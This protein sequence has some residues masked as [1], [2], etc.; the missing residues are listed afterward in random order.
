MSLKTKILVVDDDQV[1]CELL[2]EFL[3]SQGF[4]VFLA[5]CTEQ[6]LEKATQNKISLV[7][8]DIRMGDSDGLTLLQKL[9]A[10]DPFLVMIMMT[11]FGSV[12]GTIEAIQKGAFDYISKPFDLARLLALIQ[13]A[14]KHLDSLKG[15]DIKN[16]SPLAAL[17]PAKGLVG[18]SPKMVEVYKFI[19]RATLSSS[20]VLIMG[21]SGTGKELVARA[22]H[23]NSTRKSKSF[24]AINCGALS[25]SL[26]ESELFGY[27]K[28]AFTGA[29]T[30]RAGLFQEAHGGTIFLDEIGDISPLLQVKLL[31]VLQEGEIKPVGSQRAQKVDVRVIA[32][33]HRNLNQLIQ[34]GKFRE[35]LYYRLKVIEIALP[36]LRDRK[37]DILDLVDVFIQRYALSQNKNVQG[38]SQ[39][40]REA[41]LQY[42]WPGNVRQ[43]ENQVERAI[44][45][46]SSSVL[47]LEDFDFALSLNTQ[48]QITTEAHGTLENLEKDHIL[49]VLKEAHYNKSKASELLGID[50]ATLYRKAQKYGISL[51]DKE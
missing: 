40:V 1:T 34:D 46:S 49:K 27:V 31:R 51:K 39:E 28:G 20:T 30:D 2:E 29:Q 22:I 4:E 19:A 17:T 18:K 24:V 11:G 9:K 50:R 5:D 3:T 43:L 42:D 12:E 16:H 7:L 47:E 23:E 13:K 33:T 38:I 35:D 32:A 25:E 21:E 8:S 37:E 48:V 26:L 36:P 44:A 6:A 45:M 15:N 10:H 14:K 41:I